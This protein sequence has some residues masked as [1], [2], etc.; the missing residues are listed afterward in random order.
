MALTIDSKPAF[1]QKLTEMGLNDLVP[2]FTELCWS[3]FGDFGFASSAPPGT[4]PDLFEKEVLQPLLGED[5]KLSAKIRRLYAISYAIAVSEAE[6][7][8]GNEP[9]KPLTMNAAERESRREVL[10]KRLTGFA[11]AGPS[12]PAHRLIDRMATILTKGEIKYVDWSKCAERSQEIVD[13]PDVA[14][15]KM[16]KDGFVQQAFLP[17][18]PAAD[19]STDLLLDLA[20][21][22]RSLAAD[23][24]GLCS[25]EAMDAWTEVLKAA[26]LAPPPPGFSR[27]TLQQLKQADEELWR[28]CAVS[29]RT[30]CGMPP[31]ETRTSFEKAW[32]EC[33]FDYG[34]RLRLQPSRS[35]SG[36]SSSTSSSFAPAPPHARGDGNQK[37]LN[38]IANM[39]SQIENLKRKR[40]DMGSSGSKGGGKGKS[41]KGGGKKQFRVKQAPKELQ[42]KTLQT[43][44]GDNICYAFNLG[45]C[46]DA[47]PGERCPR[48]WHI[49]AQP[50]CGKPH[51]MQQNH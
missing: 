42:G 23:I 14:C 47:A 48:G 18:D 9:D 29:C 28:L 37:L 45:G 50:G 1:A 39:Q 43:L 20:L 7:A 22:R 49:C 10:A 2:K 11:L 17:H 41:K 24:A 38:Q 30:G 31:G 21:R 33:M 40:D 3:T 19:T 44:S 13:V 27:V 51:G 34:V 15:L 46:A 35:S 8:S 36:S 6:R 16:S 12:D 25:F 32:K 5:R 26:Y 4:N